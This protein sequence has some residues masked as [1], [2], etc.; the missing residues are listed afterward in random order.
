MKIVDSLGDEHV[1]VGLQGVEAIALSIVSPEFGRIGHVRLDRDQ[2]I[3]LIGELTSLV[4]DHGGGP[5]PPV[6]A[7][8]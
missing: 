2:A 7:A 4:L 1:H 3:E 8:T 5:L 6:D